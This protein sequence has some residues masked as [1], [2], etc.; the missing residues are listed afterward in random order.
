MLE[1]WAPGVRWL[2]LTASAVV[3]SVVFLVSTASAEPAHVGGTK[4]FAYDAASDDGLRRE[5][6][7]PTRIAATSNEE[8]APTAAHEPSGDNYDPSLSSVAPRT[9]RFGPANPGPLDDSV[10]ATFRSASY[11]E[12]VLSQDT[13]LYRVYGGEAGPI[14][15]YWS[16]TP[17]TGPMQAQID[18]ALNPQWGNL[19]TDVATIKVPAGTTIYEGAAAAQSLPGGGTLLGGGN[20]VFIP[21]VNSGWLVGG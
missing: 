19:A 9:T 3:A 13:L 11:D 14:G 10:A 1:R 16:R 7:T 12:V 17:P 18:L 6:D 5:S 8:I 20:Q 2:L 21:N 15:G 4:V